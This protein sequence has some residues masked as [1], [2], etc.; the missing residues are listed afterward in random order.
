MINR[1]FYLQLLLGINFLVPTFNSYF[2]DA[3]IGNIVVTAFI[4]LV[5]V[6]YFLDHD[7]CLD[8]VTLPF[9]FVFILWTGV[10]LFNAGL[11]LGRITVRDLFEVIRPF[12]YFLLFLFVQLFN[13]QVFLNYG[14]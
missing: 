1:K 8:R 5:L 9:L 10:I 7:V 14:W 6:C 11:A 2:G 13:N 4:V 3:R 12:T